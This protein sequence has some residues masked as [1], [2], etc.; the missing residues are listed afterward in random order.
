MQRESLLLMHCTMKYFY[1]YIYC[2]V[3]EYSCSCTRSVSAT[4]TLAL[5]NVNKAD[6]TCCQQLLSKI[7]LSALR[8]TDGEISC[9]D[10]CLQ[11]IY[12]HLEGRRTSNFG[13][14][15]ASSMRI[16]RALRFLEK[17]F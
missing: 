1:C 8:F 5:S 3:L 10:D 14:K 7:F 13:R 4:I 2:T 17:F 9:V 6:H 15:V 12:Q 16:M 11:M